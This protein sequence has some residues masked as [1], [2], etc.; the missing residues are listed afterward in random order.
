[1]GPSV[2]AA[3]ASVTVIVITVI[4]Q[5]INSRND[6]NLTNQEVDLLKKLDPKSKAARELNDVI[7]FRIGKWRQR[8]TKSKRLARMGIFWMVACYM[9]III[10]TLAL[11]GFGEENQ[12]AGY[13]LLAF[14]IMSTI[15]LF[16]GVVL[17]IRSAVVRSEEQIQ[18]FHMRRT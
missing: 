2:I 6:R 1:M 5:W 17:L 18:E 8:I 11:S 13:L 4:G 7:D 16:I 14:F 10:A 12:Q 15:F 3:I 9:N